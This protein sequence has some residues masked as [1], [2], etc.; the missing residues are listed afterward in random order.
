MMAGIPVPGDSRYRFIVDEF[1]KSKNIL[2][3][4]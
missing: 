3:S 4:S 1:D 2:L